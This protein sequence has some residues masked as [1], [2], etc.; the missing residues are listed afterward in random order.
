MLGSKGPDLAPL[1]RHTLPLSLVSGGLVWLHKR[2]DGQPRLDG[3]CK[4]ESHRPSY[5]SKS[6]CCQ[7]IPS[8]SHK[9]QQSEPQCIDRPPVD[10]LVASSWPLAPKPRH[11]AML[12]LTAVSGDRFL[13]AC[14]HRTSALP[15]CRSLIVELAARGQQPGR[16]W[17]GSQILDLLAANLKQPCR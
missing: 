9:T 12:D 6:H 13:Q 4:V 2:R 10:V 17:G 7:E 14:H 15:P 11:S 3:A 5:A 16:T 1:G 8:N